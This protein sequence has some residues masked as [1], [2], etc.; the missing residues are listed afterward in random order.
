MIVFFYIDTV[1]TKTRQQNDFFYIFP[2]FVPHNKAM[3]SPEQ[4]L[5]DTYIRTGIPHQLH[6]KQGF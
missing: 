6:K 1:K 3:E 4:V 5:P 2:P